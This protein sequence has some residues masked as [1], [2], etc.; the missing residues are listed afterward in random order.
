MSIGRWLAV[1]LCVVVSGTSVAAEQ[2]ALVSLL[3]PLNLRAYAAGTTPPPFAGPTLGGTLAMTDVR[4]KVVFV[5]FWASWCVECR[6]EMPALER[7][8]REF[9]PR[10]LAIVG[11][12]AR[13]PATAVRRY[14]TELGL[15]FPLVL[16]PDGTITTRYGVIGLPAT[17]LVGRDGRAVAF[18]VGARAWES[19]AARALIEAMLAEAGPR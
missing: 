10:G 8:H 13:E 14:A 11:V 7:L 6:P 12:N 19:P 9:G 4:G 3:R 16:D 15:T 17:F 18:G 2:P 5:N 1:S